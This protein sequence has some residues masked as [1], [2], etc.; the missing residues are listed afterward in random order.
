[1]VVHTCHPSLKGSIN[2]RMEILAHQIIN[3]ET[4]LEK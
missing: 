4:L 1:M 2:W 3:T